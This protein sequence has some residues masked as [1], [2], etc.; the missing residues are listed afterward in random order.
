[1]KPFAFS[2][3][4]RYVV[5]LLLLIFTAVCGGC[6]RTASTEQAKIAASLSAAVKPYN[7][8][9]AVIYKNDELLAEYYKEGYNNTSLFPVYSCTKSILSVLIG[10]ASDEGAIKSTE[11]YAAEFFPAAKI[12]PASPGKGQIRLHH[13]LNQTSGF[14]WPEWSSPQIIDKL[15]LSKDWVQFVLDRPLA[16]APGEKFNYNSG[17]SHLLSAVLQEVTGQNTLA[18]AKTHLFEPLGITTIEWAH[19][20]N[21]INCG[22]FGISMTVQDMAKIGLLYLHQGAWQGKQLVSKEWVQ[23][24]LTQQSE[25][26]QPLGAYGYQWWIRPAHGNVKYDIYFA[27][28]F[29]GQYIFIIPKLNA[30][31]AFTAWL[32]NEK[33]GIPIDCLEQTII[34]ILDNKLS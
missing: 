12:I 7:I 20:P 15:T 32:P 14:D 8:Y 27:S 22:G 6:I 2:R 23:R 9:S 16:A 26:W 24:S 1:M 13:L 29:G 19:D 3:Q 18:Y 30:V 5:F 33:A 21:Q 34:P 11:Q 28:G 25:G 4:I 10:I 31:A 17:N